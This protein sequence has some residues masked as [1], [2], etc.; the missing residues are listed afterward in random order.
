[1]PE[2]KTVL[3]SYIYFLFFCLTCSLHPQVKNNL[4]IFY[5]LA[6]SSI[7]KIAEHIDLPSLSLKVEL[8]NGEVYS[9]FNS[10]ILEY[11]ISRKVK[12]VS[13]NKDSS[14][15]LMY[16]I[17][18]ADTK[19]SDLFRKG[20]LG[21]YQT[22]RQLNFKGNYLFNYKIGNN[23][24]S[25]SFTYNYIDTIN[26]DDIKNIENIS[27]KFTNGTLPPEPFFTGLFE[28]VVALGTAAAAVILF[29]TIRSK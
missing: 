19:Y 28:P 4:D 8:H 11:L 23:I 3:I 14:A 7:N 1:M 13:D 22:I 27:F 21:P 10:H 6:D 16:T 2:K 17:E 15:D 20:L 24:H 29:F 25:N 18:K 5:S 9:V 26:V 12:L